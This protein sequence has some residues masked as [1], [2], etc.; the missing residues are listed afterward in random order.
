M[1]HKSQL[2][3]FSLSSEKNLKEGKQ[4]IAAIK[5]LLFCL[6]N[7][8]KSYSAISTLILSQ[9]RYSEPPPRSIFWSK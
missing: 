8:L 6:D 1:T 7:Y 5:K 9:T 2:T 3:Q 4:K